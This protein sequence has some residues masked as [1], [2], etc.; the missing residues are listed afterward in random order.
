MNKNLMA[1]IT[2]TKE[3]L[4]MYSNLHFPT[5][6]YIYLKESVQSMIET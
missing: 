2:E 3:G 5:L 4:V 1:L 6:A